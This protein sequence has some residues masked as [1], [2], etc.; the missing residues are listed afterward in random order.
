MERNTLHPL[1]R[2]A[3]LRSLAAPALVATGA[4]ASGC[5]AGPG[6]KRIVRYW[7]GFTGP[8]GR[9]MLR[10]V[11]RFNAANPDIQVIMQR[12]DWATYYN[13]LFVAGLGGRAP[14]VFILQTHSVPRFAQASFV[15]PVDDLAANARDL[16]IGDI[17]ANVWQAV[18]VV[19]K[20]YGV[21][22]DVWPMGMY[23]NRR[24]FREAGIVDAQGQAKP[25]TDRAEFLDAI[26]K[27]TRPAQGS[28]P[29]QW[30]FVFTNFESNVYSMMQQFNGVFFTDGNAKCVVN[31]PRNVAALQMC[32]DIIRKEKCA[33][34]PE[35][36]DA[37]IG[38][39]QGTAAIAFEGIYMLADLQK[40]KDLDFGGAPVPLLGDRRAVWAGSHNVCIRG[41]LQGADLDAAWRF[42][43]FLSNNSLDWAEGG[44]VPVR[45]SLRGTPR[46]AGMEVQSQFAREIPYA[47]YLPRLPFIFEFQTE[48]N[49]AIEKALRAS[50][51]PQQALD[52]A[53]HNINQIIERQRQNGQAIS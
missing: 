42:I 45:K 32:V 41:D 15:R 17:D 20:H 31:D 29:A 16:D 4:L 43:T 5:A 28:K 22:L 7:N 1:T 35:N 2:R 36:F 37:W 25:P 8:D 44:Q 40:Q 48:F 12:M 39:R 34:P 26:R 19:G 51:S 38:F 11:Q 33:P 18:S 21:P 49:T 30:G 50:E 10:M 46:F 53:A 47:V 6:R 13:K 14:E 52:S 24:L 9:T 23:Y 3:F 27:L